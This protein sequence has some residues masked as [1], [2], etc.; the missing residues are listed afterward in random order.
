LQAINTGILIEGDLLPSE[1]QF[2][3][4]LKISRITVRKALAKLVEGTQT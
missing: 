1:Q 2:T 4:E 3:E